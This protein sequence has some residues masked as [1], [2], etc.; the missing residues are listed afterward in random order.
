MGGGLAAT[1][2]CM[3]CAVLC[4]GA[5][6]CVQ[7]MTMVNF[8]MQD[9]LRDLVQDNVKKYVDFLHFSTSYK[10]G[11]QSTNSVLVTRTDSFTPSGIHSVL[12]LVSCVCVCVCVTL[13]FVRCSLAAETD[14]KG[15]DVKSEPA[16]AK[17]LRP[18]GSSGASAS[19]AAGVGR[20][21]DFSLFSVDLLLKDGV[22][23]YSTLPA[24]FVDTPLALFDRAL[25]TLHDI[26]QLETKV[27][28]QLFR[29][30]NSGEPKLASVRKQEEW[31]EDLYDRMQDDLDR[32]VAPLH[33]YL[34][35]VLC[36][37]LCLWCVVLRCTDHH[38]PCCV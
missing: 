36:A 25:Q 37:V 19:A 23:Q 21:A 1:R 16:P 5:I 22:I 14:S 28:E 30:G 17:V 3:T 29:A 8:M 27:M 9:A 11:V 34:A 33:V 35:T 18:A 38:T 12:L 2:S 7:L 31:V 26:P 32:A 20:A 10:V 15:L 6:G 13:R 24:Q 4:C